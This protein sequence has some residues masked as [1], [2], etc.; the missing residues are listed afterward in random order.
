MEEV[1]AI[2][3]DDETLQETTRCKKGFSCLKGNP[4]DLC[5]ID[6]CINGKIYFLELQ[7]NK[8]CL[9]C[10]AFGND[11]FCSCP[12]RQKIFTQYNM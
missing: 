1:N 2:F 11:H 9:Y 3:I 6:T 7:K 10:H 5:P 4:A 8:S 12:T